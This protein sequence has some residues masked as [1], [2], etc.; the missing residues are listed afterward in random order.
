LEY[1]S[2]RFK[3]L[4]PLEMRNELLTVLKRGIISFD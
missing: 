3:L 1:F 4:I 2:L